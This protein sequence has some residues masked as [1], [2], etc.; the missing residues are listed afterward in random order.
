MDSLQQLAELLT[1]RNAIDQQIA[2]IIGR[3]AEKGHIGDFVGAQI[4]HIALHTS[5]SNKATDGYFTEGKLTGK[6]VN[7]SYHAKIEGLMAITEDTTLDYYLILAGPKSP[8]I[9]SRGIHRPWIIDAVFLFDRSVLV[10][11]VQKRGTKLG[12]ATSVPQA[13]WEAAEIYPQSRNLLLTITAE[14]RAQLELFR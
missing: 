7:I 3:P 2:A 4:F 14:Q 9:S 1:Q 13:Q 5:G 12:V 11:M 8:P 6:S 10:D